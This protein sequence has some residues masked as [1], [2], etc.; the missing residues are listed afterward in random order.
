[1][2]L[3]LRSFPLSSE[4]Q[5][6]P[7]FHSRYFLEISGS[8]PSPQTGRDFRPGLMNS[9]HMEPGT[10]FRLEQGVFPASEP[11]NYAKKLKVVFTVWLSLF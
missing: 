7:E 6:F 5:D 11:Q 8:V 1:M 10:M 4:F 9:Y 2:F 3:V